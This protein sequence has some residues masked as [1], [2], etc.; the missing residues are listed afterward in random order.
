MT[1]SEAT[2][3]RPVRE[4]ISNV[5]KA[6]LPESMSERNVSTKKPLPE[7]RVL[8]IFTRLRVR[9]GHK[10]LSLIEDPEIHK[11]TVADWQGR[12]SGLTDEQI[13]VGLDNLPKD[14]PPSVDEFRVLCTGGDI[15]KGLS[16][17]TAA[18]IPFKRQLALEKKADKG[19]AKAAMAK[20]KSM[21]AGSGSARE[22]QR[23]IDDARQILF[24]GDSYG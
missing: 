6:G 11:L 3:M 13:I 22:R 2:T 8:R 18:Y 19:K 24:G 14:W 20:A 5:G 7:S 12:L 15:S 23:Q 10:W 16:H 1:K 9:Y 17:N 21:L 4:L